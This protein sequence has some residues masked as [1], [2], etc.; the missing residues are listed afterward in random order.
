MEEEN[1]RR[2]DKEASGSIEKNNGTGG[3]KIRMIWV[4]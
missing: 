4:K 3:K 1:K 2:E